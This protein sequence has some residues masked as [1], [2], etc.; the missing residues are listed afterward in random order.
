MKIKKI[1]K[2]LKLH[3]STISMIIGVIIILILGAFLIRYFSKKGGET[4]PPLEIIDQNL[5]ATHKVTKGE[6]LWSISEKY[7]GSG[8]FWSNI[9]EENNIKNP[10]EIEEEQ[11]LRIP[12]ISQKLS[13][14]TVSPTKTLNKEVKAEEAVSKPTTHKVERDENLW[15]IAEKY[16]D[17]GY[18]WVDIAKENKLKNPNFLNVGQEIKIPQVE[19]RIKTVKEVSSK[20]QAISSS[21]Y[22]VEKG[23]NL[24]NIS[25]RAYGDGYKWVEIAKENNLLNP[26]L[27]HPG[28]TLK[29]PR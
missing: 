13:E 24:W 29:L 10:D 17:S 1:L 28:N 26:N 23:D 8:Y 3:E 5:I 9:A 16:Y 27:I 22:T 6:T 2:K 12:N 4:I 15:M 11:T 14:I 21:T 19:P 7:Y 20:S 25:V 18:N